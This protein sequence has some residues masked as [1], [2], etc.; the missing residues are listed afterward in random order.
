MTTTRQTAG[1]A[2]NILGAR[3]ERQIRYDLSD[4]AR[5]GRIIDWQQ[6]GPLTQRTGPGGKKLVIIETEGPVDFCAWAGPRSW[7]WEAKATANSRWSFGDLQPHQARRLTT[8]LRPDA[9]R[10]AGIALRYDLDDVQTD[11]WLDWEHVVLLWSRWATNQAGRGDASLH[12]D[13]A[14]AMGVEWNSEVF[15]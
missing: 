13:D 9:K 7:A 1:R 2:A 5:E 12:I 6:Q 3:W 11:L 4:W 8:W 14:V 10:R 15:R